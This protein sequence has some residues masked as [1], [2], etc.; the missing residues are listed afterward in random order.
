MKHLFLITGTLALLAST[1]CKKWAESKLPASP[2]FLEVVWK[3]PVVDTTA[4]VETRGIT[5]IIYEDM[6]IFSTDYTLN[7]KN[8]PIMLINAKNG[9]IENYWMD[10]KRESSES[11][12]VLS[13]NFLIFGNKSK[14]NCLN[15]TSTATQWKSNITNSSTDELYASNGYVYRCVSFK[16]GAT[17]VNTS[18]ILRSPASV[19]VWDT[20]FS[21]AH[22]DNY[23]HR[24]LGCAF[25]N[26]P[27]GDDVIVWKNE[28]N[29]SSYMYNTEVFAYNLLAD[30]LLWRN[31]DFEGRSEE[32]P[33]KI[34][35]GVV[36]SLIHNK[37]IALDLA[38]GST[39]WSCAIPG[40]QSFS[41]GCDFHIE[42]DNV[43]VKDPD[44]KLYY[45]NKSYGYIN[46][47]V[48]GLP[49]LTGK[50]VY[51]EGKLIGTGDRLAIIDIDTGQDLLK[52]YS[53]IHPVKD[54]FRIWFT[55]ISVDPVRRVM[56]ASD[57]IYAYCIKI[58]DL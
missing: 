14:I 1:G 30:S 50:Y 55:G 5:P 24:F 18:A 32:L 8:H 36:Y 19:E 4:G 54:W 23:S 35:D 22:A 57:G 20:V 16:Q 31:R 10:H 13:D 33:L 34:V 45:I 53:L 48:Q 56:Y 11:N 2:K 21:F 7:G 6:V 38:N 43:L 41:W 26:L 42:G 29:A 17:S 28:V 58:P 3:T 12:P 15:L 40:N 39:R 47:M 52:D 27:N 44:D 49:S 51:F 9:I 37:A 46:R 25:G